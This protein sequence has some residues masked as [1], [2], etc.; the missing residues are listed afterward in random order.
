MCRLL[1][2]ELYYISDSIHE[3]CPLAF[4]EENK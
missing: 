2:K 4:E 3:E 1:N